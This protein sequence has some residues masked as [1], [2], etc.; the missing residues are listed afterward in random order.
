MEVFSCVCLGVSGGGGVTETQLLSAL[1]YFETRRKSNSKR[2]TMPARRSVQNQLSTL[3]ANL[4]EL[5][6]WS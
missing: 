1:V 5:T 6:S 3:G 2:E 4:L